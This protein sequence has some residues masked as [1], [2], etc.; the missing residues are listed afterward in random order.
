MPSLS[1]L[2]AVGGKADGLRHDLE[3]VVF[4]PLHVIHQVGGLQLVAQ[5][6]QSRHQGKHG[7]IFIMKVAS[8]HPGIE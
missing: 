7:N 8:E 5:T 6:L 3:Q 2:Q 4:I 1:C